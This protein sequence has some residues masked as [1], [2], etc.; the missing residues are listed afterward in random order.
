MYLLFDFEDFF[1]YNLYILDLYSIN[2]Q[3]IEIENLWIYHGFTMVC[4]LDINSDCNSQL[5]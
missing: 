1:L 4:Q 3:L 2:A 5:R